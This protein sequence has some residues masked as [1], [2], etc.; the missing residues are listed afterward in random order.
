MG[1]IGAD[2]RLKSH[3]S[4][5]NVYM[6]FLLQFP[7]YCPNFSYCIF[8]LNFFSRMSRQTGPGNWKPLFTQIIIHDFRSRNTIFLALLQFCA[9]F[10]FPG[11]STEQTSSGF[12][13]FK[14]IYITKSPMQISNTNA[15]INSDRPVP[16]KQCEN[17]SYLRQKTKWQSLAESNC[18]T[19]TVF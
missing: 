2:G 3:E 13:L 11:R 14:V 8:S 19:E 5:Y 6:K 17:T 4:I 10:S 9:T 18:E 16:V 15:G 7:S 12:L 1:W